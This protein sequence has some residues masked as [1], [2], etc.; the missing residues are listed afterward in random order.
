MNFRKTTWTAA[1]VLL[2]AACT[3]QAGA[4]NYTINF[5]GESDLL[6]TGSFTYDAAAPLF[7][8][9]I[10]SW[11]GLTFDLTAS[12][13]APND[14]GAGGPACLGGLAGP[15]AGFAWMNPGCQTFPVGWAGDATP[16]GN[17]VIGAFDFLESDSNRQITAPH[18]DGTN[19]I[20]DD[21]GRQ[22]TFTISAA[23][24][25]SPTPEPATFGVILGGLGLLVLRRIRQNTAVAR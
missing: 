24:S 13:N 17:N 25:T 18:V 5:V 4:I 15:A 10:V 1:L 2:G 14:V 3:L 6:P 9:F 12:A 20:D 11:D 19:A 23:S 7:T 22:G 8:N 16:V 21:T